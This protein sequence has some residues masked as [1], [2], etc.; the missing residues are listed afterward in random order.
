MS[1]SMKEKSKVSL[2]VLLTIQ[3]VSDISALKNDTSRIRK[4]WYSLSG[5]KLLSLPSFGDI[6]IFTKEKSNKKK[7]LK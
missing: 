4:T 5:G 2:D 6:R 7:Q 3:P 1:L